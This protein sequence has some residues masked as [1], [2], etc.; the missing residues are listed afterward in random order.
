MNLW[1]KAKHILSA[2]IQTTFLGLSKP[3]Q[4]SGTLRKI[5]LSTPCSYMKQEKKGTPL[6][7][8]IIRVGLSDSHHYKTVLMAFLYAHVCT[9]ANLYYILI[10]N[11]MKDFSKCELASTHCHTI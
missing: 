2:H 4:L 5:D 3:F 6:H 8:S 10:Q 9:V 11:Y 7:P 1:E